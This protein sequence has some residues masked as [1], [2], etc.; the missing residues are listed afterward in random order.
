MKIKF[1]NLY[2]QNNHFLKSFIFSLKKKI[3]NSNFIGG[4]EIDLLERNFRKIFNSKYC[5]SVANGT[6]A[7]IISLKCLGVG[8]GDEVIVPNHT[9]VSTAG[10]VIA[11]GATPVFVDTDEYFTIN[12]NQIEKKISKKTKAIIPVHLYGQSCEMKKILQIS[13]RFNL[14]IIED[15][16]QAHL[17]KYDKK[18][19]GNFGDVGTFSFFPGKNLGAFGDAGIII[20]NKK[21]IFDKIRKFKNHG[22]IQK[23]E[24]K[25][26]GINSRLDVIQ[27]LILNKKIHHLKRYNFRRRKVVA[28]Y[29][30]QL[31]D[32]NFIELPKIRNLSEHTYH[33]FV[34]IIKNKIYRDLLKKF[35]KS[36]DVETSIHYPKMITNLKPYKI[37]KGK[38]KFKISATY[39]KKILSL[40]IHPFMSKKET[41][42]VSKLINFFFDKINK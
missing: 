26:F 15:C 24:H 25:T 42:Y 35:L 12:T 18:I 21:D 38:D 3:K 14:K 17:T 19:V 30:E 6:D 20:C 36:R 23:N 37:Y 33:Q 4:Y 1:N 11:V 13:K 2:L 27:A 31:K 16:A 7:L 32:N 34:I 9:W 29:R 28:I 8:H 41:L 10:S 5:V 22:S 40:P 39:E